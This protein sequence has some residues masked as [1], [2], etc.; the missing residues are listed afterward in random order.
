MSVIV[1]SGALPST[2]TASDIIKRAYR[3]LG[4]LEL[5]E[6][7]NTSQATI[8]LDALNA[9]LDSFSLEKLLVYHVRQES[10]AWT[11]LSVSNTIGPSGD[12][13][14]H[15]PIRVEQGTYFIDN[16]NIAYHPKIVRNRETYDR[17]ID[18]TVQ[19]TYPDMLFYDPSV[20]IGTLYVYPIPNVNLTLKI[21]QW[22]PLQIFDTLTEVFVLPHGYWRML[23]FNLAVELEAETGLPVPPGARQIASTSKMAIKRANSLPIYAS[24]EIP[25]VLHARGRSDIV[26]GE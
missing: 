14:T 10:F 11:A 2:V 26:A 17:I 6:A 22:Q 20:T 23:C 9:M 7:L 12:F 1:E 19:S 15:R 3:I 13:D 18:K 5:N 16:N 8:G 25:F 4:D 21:N 24:T